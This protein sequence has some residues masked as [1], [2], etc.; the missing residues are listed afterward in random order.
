MKQN[1]DRVKIQNKQAWVDTIVYL[2]PFYWDGYCHDGETATNC[3]GHGTA[4]GDCAC[5]YVSKYLK[6]YAK[7]VKGELE[8]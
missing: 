8:I 3:T 6:T 7:F 2:C 4:T 5:T 1:T